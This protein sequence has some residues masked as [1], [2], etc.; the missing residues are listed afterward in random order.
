MKQILG[1]L[2]AAMM[3]L[4]LLATPALGLSVDEAILLLEYC[5]VDVLPEALY[6]AE[7][8]DE[9]MLLLGDPYTRYMTEKEYQGFLNNLEQE[10]NFVGIGVYI[11]LSDEGIVVEN[12][13]AGGGAQRAGLTAGD[14]ILAVD[15]VSCVPAA[16]DHQ[17]MILGEEGS[18]VALTLRRPDG[19]VQEVQVER[20]MVMLQNTTV[21]LIAPT[22]GYVDCNSFGVETGQ[23]IRNGV[24]LYE[25]QADIWL[26][27]LRGNGGG[28]TQSAVE[29]ISVFA[30]AGQHLLYQSRE[31]LSGERTA[32]PAVTADR[33]VV[34]VDEISASASELMTAGLRDQ[35]GAVSVGSRTFGKGVAQV[36]LDGQTLPELFDKDAMKVTAYRFYSPLGSTNDLMG[37]LPT[38]MVDGQWAEGVALALCGTG[39]NSGNRLRLELN[40]A[41]YDVDTVQT[42]P[43]VLEALLEALPPDV[44][45]W[46]EV[47][48]EWVP[49][50]VEEAA[51]CLGLSIQPVRFGDVVD[52]PH[53]NAIHTLA[54]YGILNGMDADSFQPEGL[55][56]RAQMAALLYQALGR[57]AAYGSR[58]ADVSPDAWYGPAVQAMDRMGL[59][60]GVSEDH[61]DPDGLLT[62]EQFITLMGRLARWLNCY[63]ELY[64]NSLEAELLAAD[65][66]TAPY[67]PWAR[68]G[69]AVLTRAAQE[70]FGMD[71]L[72]LHAS[73]ADLQPG[74]GVL[75]EQAAATLYQILT[76]LGILA[77]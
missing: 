74:E 4:C 12:V 11:R 42:I 50:T 19:L 21:E 43:P 17:Q 53:A 60:T 47:A 13:V 67:A 32:E 59:M 68:E 35:V 57:P 51:T 31:G 26:L 18:M 30:G 63:V 27:D 75:R 9:L 28:W 38:L 55:L 41:S 77:Y 37:L 72:M 24:A 71:V 25:E 58:F 66:L 2:C 22:V 8:V 29:G 54:T 39:Q 76:V 36:I 3:A 46:R 15:G 16:T 20:R 61:F 45:L 62:Q 49:T 69:V 52:S 64:G 40:G 33:V 56:T 5:Y 10:E 23:Y 6:Q 34:L 48:G 14:V 1:R 73:P 65:P 44:P 70:V 7:S